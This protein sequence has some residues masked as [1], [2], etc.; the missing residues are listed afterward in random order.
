MKRRVDIDSITSQTFDLIIIGGGITGAGILQ[1]A[2][3]NG[4]KCLLLEKGDFASG[5]TSKS[6]K[7]IHGGM[8]YMKYGKLGMVRESL[9][10][11]NY[12]L[13]TYPHLVK[14]LPFLFPVYDSKLKYS[15]GVALYH[16]L[17]RENVLPDYQSLE[18]GD[19]IKKF[20]AATTEG[21]L[22][23]FLY[24]DAVTN[25]ARL[26]NEV[27]HSAIRN[28]DS[29]ALNYCEVQS[30]FTAKDTVLVECHDHIEKTDIKFQCIYLVN[31]TGVWTD[32]V[33]KK[34]VSEKSGISAP[35][36]GVHLVLSKRRFP[37]ETAVIFP[38]YA[39]DERMMYAL[40]WE[41]DSVIIGTT[42]TEFFGRLNQFTASEDDVNYIIHSIREFA[43]SLDVTEKDIL[44]VY[45]GLRP[46]LRENKTS[47]ERTRDYNI[48]W[49]NPRLLNIFGGKL[50]SFH[51]MAKALVDE[52][53]G[54][55]SPSSSP[56]SVM[57]EKINSYN[58][59]EK[60]HPDFE[61][62]I[63]EARHFISDQQCYHLDDLLTRRLS[64]TYVL[65]GCKDKNE[66]I[67]KIAELM[68]EECGWTWKEHEEEIKNYND[69]LS[70]ASKNFTY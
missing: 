56:V 30:C 22:G 54:K 11:R 19:V 47:S 42:D 57:R 18:A 43:P 3:L 2:S 5:T 51:S 6:A 31:A 24:Y 10:E 65:N 70:N 12:L 53:K 39:G 23:G 69:L 64:L 26:C 29:V 37:A 15:L 49:S 36:K 60:I 32:E 40:P 34:L 52:L 16:F 38:S 21:L 45:A 9:E 68:K 67:A 20:P 1:E 35:S 4:Y 58:V 46:L 25:D 33:R 50:T 44:F 41:N 66:I 55:A 59:G 13:K 14:P 17:D 63:S 27:I 48:W 8:R 7:L 62:T 28:S 61:A